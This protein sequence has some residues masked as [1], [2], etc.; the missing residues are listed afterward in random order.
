MS[1]R[2]RLSFHFV[3]QYQSK[4][5]WS[6]L[7]QIYLISDHFLKTFKHKIHWNLIITNPS[8]TYDYMIRHLDN[9]TKDEI[10]AY[11]RFNG[12]MSK[13][14]EFLLLKEMIN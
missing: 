12:R 13:L 1:T 8:F 3:E 6:K 11:V 7:T 5:N 2:H 4:L 14:Q 9:F 10:N